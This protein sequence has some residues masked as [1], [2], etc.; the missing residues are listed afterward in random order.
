VPFLGEPVRMQRYKPSMLLDGSMKD[1]KVDEW[2]MFV[3][4]YWPLR[5]IIA[6]C[7]L[8]SVTRSL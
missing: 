8:Q 5:W 6:E 3:T 4:M 1:G 7:E 2:M